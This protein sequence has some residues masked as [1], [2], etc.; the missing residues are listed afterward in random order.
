MNAS[1]EIVDE[2]RVAVAWL[3]AREVVSSITITVKHLSLN[4]QVLQLNKKTQSVI[5]PRANQIMITHQFEDRR[6]YLSIGRYYTL[7]DKA[8]LATTTLS[9]ATLS[10]LMPQKDKLSIDN[11][12]FD[13]LK[14]PATALSP[15]IRDGII[16]TLYIQTLLG[17]GQF[18]KEDRS[19]LPLLWNT[20]FCV[21]APAFLRAY[22]EDAFDL[23][24]KDNVH[25]IEIAELSSLPDFLEK[26]LVNLQQ[27]LKDKDGFSS[28]LILASL[29]VFV[30]THGKLPAYILQSKEKS[31]LLNKIFLLDPRWD[32]LCLTSI[33]LLLKRLQL[34][35]DSKWLSEFKNFSG[36][37]DYDRLSD[38]K[39]NT[40]IIELVFIVLLGY[41]YSILNPVFKRIS[42]DKRVRKTLGK[43]KL[44][45][46]YAFP[47]VPTSYRERLK[48]VLTDLADV[49]IP[50]KPL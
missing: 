32:E 30:T 22:Y 4:E 11:K 43:I 31:D 20:S 39:Y 7:V 19:A 41:E 27:K 8:T 38:E 47:R 25:V 46:E 10:M 29:E 5:T 40:I 1:S 12:A 37:I 36:Q 15:K 33:V 2:K 34:Y 45:L 16:Q 50:E 48:R 42:T 21:S 17:K 14:E 44:W 3:M 28:A 23:I 26:E 9:A 24:G 18:P 13:G 6:K 49:S 35:G